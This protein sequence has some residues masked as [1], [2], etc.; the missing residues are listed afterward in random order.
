VSGWALTR[1]CA[2]AEP[3]SVRPDHGLGFT[4]PL[5][6]PYTTAV[7]QLQVTWPQVVPWLEHCWRK[8]VVLA[9]AGISAM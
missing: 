5:L 7:R 2:P 3:V 9:C 8:T 4:D 6:I 1:H